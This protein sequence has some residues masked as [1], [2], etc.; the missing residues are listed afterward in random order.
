MDNLKFIVPG[1]PEYMTM[2]R[3]ATSSLAAQ[4]GFDVDATEDIK[5]AVVEACKNVSCHGQEGYSEKYEIDEDLIFAI[6]KNESNFKNAISSNK[7][8]QGLMQLME[9]TAL[10]VAEAMGLSNVDLSNPKTNI[11]IGTKFYSYLYSKYENDGLALAAY[12]AGQGNV[13]SWIEE[14]IINEEGSNLE[15]IPFKETNMYVRKVSRDYKIYS[16]LYK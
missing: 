4:A 3:L 7:G 8:A 9:A 16:R 14:G 10:E 2:I 11:E 6:I 1:K 13:D 15:N 12:N 5:I